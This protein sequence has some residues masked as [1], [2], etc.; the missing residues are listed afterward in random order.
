MMSEPTYVVS[1]GKAVREVD[2]LVLSVTSADAS[3]PSSFVPS[4]D[5]SRPSTLP[6]VIRFGTVTS[7]VKVA[8]VKAAYPSPEMYAA[9]QDEPV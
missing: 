2:T 3:M 8:P 7:P 9:T 5:T 1:V 4:A 6:L